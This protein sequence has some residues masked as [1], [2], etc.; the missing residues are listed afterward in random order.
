MTGMVIFAA[1][2]IVSASVGLAAAVGQSIGF[3]TG[4]FQTEFGWAFFIG[5]YLS[6]V[7][8]KNIAHLLRSRFY[9]PEWIWARSRHMDSAYLADEL[10]W[11]VFPNTF[12]TI[13]EL[14]KVPSAKFYL[15]YLGPLAMDNVLV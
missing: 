14:R 13:T 7:V 1:C 11:T 4:G 15:G 3:L 10:W 9:P 5:L 2:P 12:D 6:L 8:H